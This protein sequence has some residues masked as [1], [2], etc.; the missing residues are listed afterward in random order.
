M[1]IRIND[2]W[3]ICFR[4]SAGNANADRSE[5][6]LSAR[7]TDALRIHLPQHRQGFGSAGN[8]KIGS[9]GVTPS[10]LNRWPEGE[11]PD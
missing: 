8:N 5:K 11:T 9:C 6:C 3:R 10:V 1:S 4:W 7:R 2:Q